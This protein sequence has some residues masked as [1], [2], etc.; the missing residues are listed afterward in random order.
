MTGRTF[1]IDPAVQG[2]VSVVTQRPLSR[3]EY[4]ELFLSTLRANGLSRCRSGRR[5]PH[6]AGRDGAAAGGAG[7]RR[8]AAPTASSPRS[9]ASATSRRR[10]RSRRCG[11]WSAATARSPPAA[12]RSS[13]P[14][15]PTMSPASARCFA[16]IDRDT[17][18][19]AGSSAS[20]C[21]RARDRDAL[22]ALMEGSAGGRAATIVPVDS[23]N[24]I[25]LRGDAATVARLA[26]IADELDQRAASGSEIRVIFLEHAD[27]EQLL[28]VLQQLLGQTPTQPPPTPACRARGDEH[29]R[30]DQRAAAAAAPAR[31]DDDRAGRRRRRPPAATGGSVVRP[32][33][34]GRHPLRGRQRDR[35]RRADRR[36]AHARR[37][38][39]P[40]RHPPPAGAGRG[41]HRRDFRHRRQAARRPAAARRPRAAATSRSRSP[42][43]PT[44]AQPADRRRRD[45]GASGCGRR[46]RRSTA[47]S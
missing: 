38:D 35:H 23:S 44:P 33:Q 39:P 30:V 5:V 3:S 17:Q 13:S 15:S 10:R 21:R 7:R 14:T 46:R 9:S 19:R 8:A 16:S 2:K 26:A 24:S 29:D 41:D 34:R 45:R 1:I 42:I 11:R 32:A 12:T 37:G 20:Q 28:P 6:P 25:A 40:A 36:P 43:I 22:N 4:F 27:A 18:L 47:R 31:H